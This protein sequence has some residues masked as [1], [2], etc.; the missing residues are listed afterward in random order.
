MMC[1][2]SGTGEGNPGAAAREGGAR[3]ERKMDGMDG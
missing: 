2:F 3:C 1:L